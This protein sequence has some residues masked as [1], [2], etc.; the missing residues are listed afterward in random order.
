[1]K[2]LIAF[3]YVLVFFAIAGL[4]TDI[5]KH[6]GQPHPVRQAAILASVWPLT[7]PALTLIAIGMEILK[8]EWVPS[9]PRPPRQTSPNGGP[10]KDRVWK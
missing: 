7:M 6:Q 4:L 1:M 2:I 8:L 10:P 5:F 3:W 9:R